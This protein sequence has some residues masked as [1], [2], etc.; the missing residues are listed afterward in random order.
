MTV[1]LIVISS[2]LVHGDDED[3][4]GEGLF[5]DG[6]GYI[7]PYL[8][9]TSDLGN[10]TGNLSS[11]NTSISE[12]ITGISEDSTNNGENTTND[13]E[14]DT[15]IGEGLFIDDEGY[16]GP[17]L[18]NLSNNSSKNATNMSS[19]TYEAR[20]ITSFPEIDRER[21]IMDIGFDEG[22]FADF[23]GIMGHFGGFTTD[24]FF[25]GRRHQP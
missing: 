9:N 15:N 11:N 20:E 1:L 3:T 25:D 10:Y 23:Q 22:F 14:N 4:I 21:L 13:G 12:N 18:A 6:E 2:S 7:G 19:S 5:I 8:A 17:Y 16:I 24:N